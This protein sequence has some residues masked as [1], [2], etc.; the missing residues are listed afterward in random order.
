M[1]RR[2]RPIV[3]ICAVVCAAGALILCAALPGYHRTAL[4][5][6][7]GAPRVAPG[8][9]TDAP[10]RAAELQALI[11]GAMQTSAAFYGQPARAPR[12][13]VC[14]TPACAAR[15]GLHVRAVALGARTILVSPGGV[16]PMIFA[17]EQLHIDLR[18]HMTL[19]DVL[20]PRFPAWFDEGLASHV[21][22]DDRL[23]QMTAQQARFALALRSRRDWGRANSIATWRRTYG[24]ARALVTDLEARIGRAGL[25]ALIAETARSGD[26][27]AALARLVGPD[28][29]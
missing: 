22:G 16:T 4:P 20:A 7:F 15:F 18:Q 5:G 21:S 8:L 29:P 19:R 23:D 13:I 25:R 9:Y 3:Q 17:H 12:V 1:A 11:S 2:L 26:F 28:W 6:M 27:D 14:T 10:E 24:A